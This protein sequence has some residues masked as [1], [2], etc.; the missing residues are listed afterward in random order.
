[1]ETK[2]VKTNIRKLLRNTGEVKPMAAKKAVAGQLRCSVR[3]IEMML[4]GQR[5]SFQ[6]AEL[7]KSKLTL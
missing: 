5:V 3:F 4:K 2:T 6:M 7:I 1:M